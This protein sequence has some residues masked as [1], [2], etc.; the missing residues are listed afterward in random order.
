MT[1]KLWNLLSFTKKKKKKQ[2]KLYTHTQ[3]QYVY[4]PTSN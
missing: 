3:Q 2:E 1:T 4:L